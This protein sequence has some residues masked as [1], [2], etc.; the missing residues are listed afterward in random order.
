MNCNA[1][2][3]HT[4]SGFKYKCG[5]CSI[6]C[7]PFTIPLPVSISFSGRGWR[8]PFRETDRQKPVTPSRSGKLPLHSFL[9]KSEEQLVRRLDERISCKKPL[10][11][12]SS[13]PRH[14]KKSREFYS[15]KNREK[16]KEL[17]ANDWELGWR[18]ESSGGTDRVESGHSY[19]GLFAL[20]HAFVNWQ[21]YK[22]TI[23]IRW[24]GHTLQR[25]DKT[26]NANVH[27][28]A[29]KNTVF[30]LKKKGA[31]KHRWHKQ[32]SV[33]QMDI[34]HATPTLLVWRSPA[35]QGF[36]WWIQLLNYQSSV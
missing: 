27:A 7:A 28:S 17:C 6:I 26:C 24:S 32:V 15:K 13:T 20:V 22:H 9:Q 21:G 16:P 1:S 36:R 29:N 11:M 4:K 19:Q 2:R 31:N 3:I 18:N 34:Y 23:S 14:L 33:F 25:T 12:G 30:I 5:N 8:S 10:G 35:A